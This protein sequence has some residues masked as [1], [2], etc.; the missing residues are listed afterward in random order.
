ME[1]S[2]L[3][4]SWNRVAGLCP[5]LATQVR[6][7]RQVYRGEPWHILHD[8]ISND[9]YRLNPIAHH[10]VGLLDGRR[11]VDE[12]WRLALDRFGDD[13]P[14][15][16]EVI[17]LLGQ[18]HGS[19]LLRVDLP[20]DAAA[21]LARRRQRRLRQWGGQAQSILFLRISLF[22][23]DRLLCWL[24]PF[25]R[26]LLTRVGLLLWLVWIGV[27][28]WRFAP[29]VPQFLRDADSVLAPA[30]WGWLVALFLV[31]KAI[32]ELGHGLMCRRFGGPVP[33]MGVM[34][35]VLFPAPFVDATSAW[36][37]PDKW[38]RLLVSAAGMMFELAIAAGAA[39][40]WLG[41]RQQDPGSLTQQLAYNTV[42]LASVTTLL[43]NANPL[44]RFDGYYLLS[45]LLE[46][47]NLYERSRQQ[48]YGLVQRFAFG[49]GERP[50]V[51]STTRERA[52]LVIYG[53]S[54]S[55]YRVLVLFGIVLF[56]I[57]KLYVIGLLLGLWSL[58]AWA[59]LPALKLA[60]WL[61]ASP[62]VAEHRG[63]AVGV[64][65]AAVAVVAALVGLIPMPEHR[66]AQ[67]VIESAASSELVAEVDGR[68]VEVLVGA[69][70]RVTRGTA[71]LVM[72][73]QEM[74]SRQQMVSAGLRE[75]DVAISAASEHSPAA[76]QV[77]RR[78]HAS[79]TRRL[80]ELDRQIEALTIRSPQDGAV[81]G[82]RLARLH[83]R[84]LHRGQVLGT[85]VSLADLR[86]TALVGQSEQGALFDGRSVRSVHVRTAG[87]PHVVHAATILRTFDAARHELPHPGLGHAGG[88]PI[89]I[90]PADRRGSRMLRP[91]FA[92]W[93]G[94]PEEAGG[95]PGQR[96][97]I[98]FT[99]DRP[100][101]LYRQW[102]DRV[103]RIVNMRLEG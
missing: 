28:T 19:N 48:I 95:L 12:A 82:V 35:L 33:R 64:T 62:E 23:P 16:N 77:A 102:Y 25:V 81:V 69:D 85:V 90:D 26:P 98:R 46:I 30:N 5:R 92:L 1:R 56:I 39:L 89:A 68:V 65:G 13:A 100:R 54:A 9:F 61:A 72:E 14:T 38:Q 67:G 37:F 8:P 21:L 3:S 7:H 51:A 59:L 88:G 15:Q 20:A 91:H 17:G 49:L 2:T 80:A 71:L 43:F 79:L 78:R 55:I 58:V 84:H 87:M 75:L 76:R 24:L 42:F 29:H 101:P 4:A 73:N 70:Q 11:T 99:L 96:V 53:I 74:R 93:L 41:A 32:H 18:L 66:R 86:V 22:N 103:R 94:L 45:D 44:L 27:A 36:N 47:P 40:V 6:V 60:R 34:M 97:H 63:R 31:T 83:G 52:L 50:A 57:G 10:L